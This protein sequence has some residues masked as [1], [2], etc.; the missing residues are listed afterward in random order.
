VAK[1]QD[2]SD[3]KT[4][5]APRAKAKLSKVDNA[6][7]PGGGMTEAHKRTTSLESPTQR[8]ISDE[9]I[10]HAA[11]DVWRV[12]SE[13][14]AQTLP[15]LKKSLDVSDDLVLLAVGWLAREGKLV[16]ETTGRSVTVSLR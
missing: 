9:M 14:G 6:E 10:G 12:L 3:K 11:G 15:G 2:L 13:R 1:K 7:A 5:S 8:G 16:F 4:K